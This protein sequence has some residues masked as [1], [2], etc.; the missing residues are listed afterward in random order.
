MGLR[1]QLQELIEEYEGTCNYLMESDRNWLKENNLC[2]D[3]DA[4][5]F[6][7]NVCGWWCSTGEESEEPHTCEEC[8][9]DE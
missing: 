8:Y 5:I 9:E 4:E 1:D 3:F 2:D 7:C 6:E